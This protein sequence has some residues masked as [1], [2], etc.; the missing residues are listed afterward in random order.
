MTEK[1]KRNRHVKSKPSAPE[2]PLHGLSSDEQRT[3]DEDAD[4]NPHMMDELPLLPWEEEQFD[5]FWSQEDDVAF[6]KLR[7]DIN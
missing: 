2:G 3:P 4:W 7:T 5:D 6:K 1:K